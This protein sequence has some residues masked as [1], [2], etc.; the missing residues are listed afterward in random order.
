MGERG[1]SWE[2]TGERRKPFWGVQWGGIRRASTSRRAGAHRRWAAEGLAGVRGM[3]WSW[4]PDVEVQAGG[5]RVRFLTDEEQK[6]V[7][8]K[9]YEEGKR[10]H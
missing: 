1:T 2:S 10:I 5:L 8:P 4:N 9:V 3:P 6:V 7:Q